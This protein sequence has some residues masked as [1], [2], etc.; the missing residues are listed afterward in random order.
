MNS[1][2]VESRGA[3]VTTWS[4]CP[5][6]WELIIATLEATVMCSPEISQYLLLLPMWSL[7]I[8]LWI[9]NFKPSVFELVKDDV[10]DP[11]ANHIFANTFFF[12][13]KSLLS[14]QGKWSCFE[15]KGHRTKIAIFGHLDSRAEKA[16]PI[17][18]FHWKLFLSLFYHEIIIKM[19]KITIITLHVCIILFCFFLSFSHLFIL[20][21]LYLRW[22]MFV[23]MKRLFNHLNY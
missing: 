15:G 4:V 8:G 20:S 7:D 21:L 16:N 9:S 1:T 3:L 14:E 5:L 22:N 19:M 11:I 12:I 10:L 2:Q 13:I 18:H 17:Q 23:K 6:Q